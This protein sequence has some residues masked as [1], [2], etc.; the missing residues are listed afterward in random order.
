[1]QGSLD[2]DPSDTS[3]VLQSE[4][5]RDGFIAKYDRHGSYIKVFQFGGTGDL[6]IIGLSINDGNYHP[7]CSYS[8]HAVLSPNPSEP[9]Q[10]YSQGNTDMA[11]VSFSDP[12]QAET[13]GNLE[14]QPLR[15]LPNPG[16]G[17]FLIQLNGL[18]GRRIR[19][20]VY[21]LPG[22]VV[23]DEFMLMLPLAV[24]Y[25]IAFKEEKQQNV[26]MF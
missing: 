25:V 9:V 6:Y 26:L 11:I 21:N 7:A 24:E 4:G 19:L 5:G 17:N 15:I 8:G 2:F 10:R 12:E 20:T 3:H 23:H 18:P 16:S 1:M 14:E 22:M 13:I